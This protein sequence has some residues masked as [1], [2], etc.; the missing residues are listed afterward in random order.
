MID[1]A[2]NHLR[3][4]YFPF[5]TCTSATT[6]KPQTETVNS[7][8]LVTLHYSSRKLWVLTFMLRPLN[9]YHQ[10]H[11]LMATALT[12]DSGFSAT[13]CTPP[14][15][16]NCTGMAWDTKVRSRDTPPRSP[17]DSKDLCQR[18]GA[19]HH[20]HSCVHASMGL[21]QVQSTIG[22]PLIGGI[23]WCLVRGP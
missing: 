11:L 15:C 16:R 9:T 23:L 20:H 21:S 5:F 10:V 7:I 6:L 3:N 2:E 14:H 18:P 1:W 12:D 8:D 4:S 19:R 13:Q 22:P 17:Q